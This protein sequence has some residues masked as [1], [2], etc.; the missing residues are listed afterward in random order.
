[1]KTKN[2]KFKNWLTAR[3]ACDDAM[4]WAATLAY[5]LKRVYD[6]CHRGDW[7]LWWARRVDIDRELM[8]TELVQI[9]AMCHRFYTE[10]CTSKEGGGKP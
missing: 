1:M 8:K 9:A 5:D 6:E 3:G 4:E 10:L 2:L 7:L